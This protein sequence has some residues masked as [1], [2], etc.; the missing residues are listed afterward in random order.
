MWTCIQAEAVIGKEMESQYKT[1]QARLKWR[2]SG[3]SRKCQGVEWAEG[4]SM[5]LNC[6]SIRQSSEWRKKQQPPQEQYRAKSEGVIW[7]PFYVQKYFTSTALHISLPALEF[8]APPPC[9]TELKKYK[10]KAEK[11][12]AGKYLAC[13]YMVKESLW[14]PLIPGYLFYA[15]A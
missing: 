3:S 13:K 4:E 6:L 2:P 1:L 7:L 5:V 14:F 11:W 10:S 15:Y 8:C 12:E 9:K